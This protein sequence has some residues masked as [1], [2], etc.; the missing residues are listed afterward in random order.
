MCHD[1]FHFFS[2]GFDHPA[3]LVLAERF[4][5]FGTLVGVRKGVGWPH[6]FNIHFRP[7]AETITGSEQGYGLR[8]IAL[9]RD[10]SD[11]LVS[12][13]LHELI[14]CMGVQVPHGEVFATGCMKQRKKRRS[15]AKT[16]QPV[17]YNGCN[18]QGVTLR[19][20]ALSNQLFNRTL[21]GRSDVVIALTVK[22]PEVSGSYRGGTFGKRNHGVCRI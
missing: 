6:R 9:L 11:G 5:T 17:T 7:K 21:T 15:F 22:R 3:F 12:Q 16:V 2:Q 14:D 20:Q 19:L 10:V 1:P 13:V 8:V 4:L 18:R